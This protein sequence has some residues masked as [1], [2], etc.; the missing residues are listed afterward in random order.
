M[1]AGS[2]R[3]CLADHAPIHRLPAF[4]AHPLL[5]DPA[6]APYKFPYEF[7]SNNVFSSFLH[8][9]NQY[10]VISSIHKSRRGLDIVTARYGEDGHAGGHDECCVVPD[11][12]ARSTLVLLSGGRNL[13]QVSGGHN[14]HI[15]IALRTQFS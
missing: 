14:L 1:A 5:A 8:S 9:L 10:S 3:A 6:L 2:P 13:M 4:L 7:A 15:W 12:V 11:M